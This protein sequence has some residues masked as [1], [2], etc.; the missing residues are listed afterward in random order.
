M[1]EVAISLV[2]HL[3]GDPDLRYTPNGV[4]VCDI[5][6]ATTPRRKVGD[7]WQDK[8]TLWFNLTCWRELAEQ[9]A[10]SF[11]KGDRLVV[12]GKLLQ[13]TYE[14]NDGTIGTKL[15]IDATAVGADV[16]R[17][18]VEVKRTVRPGSTADLMPE[19]WLNQATGEIVSAVPQGD[20]GPLVPFL[21][22]EVAVQTAEEAAA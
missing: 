2:G 14:R 8:E 1:N 7:E 6:L 20:P 17:Y 11:K 21:E 3:G 15:V 22:D 19:K 13:Q 4:P 9:V 18:A 10:E 16:S 12:Q 5:R